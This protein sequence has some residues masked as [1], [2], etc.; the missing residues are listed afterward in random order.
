[1]ALAKTGNYQ[2][3]RDAFFKFRVLCSEKKFNWKQI[4]AND[5]DM[6]KEISL[7]NYWS[8]EEATK[9][10]NIMSQFKNDLKAHGLNMNEVPRPA[11]SSSQEPKK[12]Q[13]TARIESLTYKEGK[14]CLFI[15]PNQEKLKDIRDLKT[16]K[17]RNET[18]D[19]E[20][21]ND[22]I[23]ELRGLCK[24]HNIMIGY[25]ASKMLDEYESNFEQSYS[26][27]RVELNLPFR[28]NV[29]PYDYQTV[30]ISFGIRTLKSWNCD[31]MGLGKTIQG[32][33]TALGVDQW[34]VIV[35]CPKSLRYNWKVEIEKFTKK[36][37]IIATHK[38]MEDL[39][40]M[41]RRNEFDFLIMNHDG[42]KSFFVNEIERKVDK[43]NRKRVNVTL[44]GLEKLFKGIIIDEVHEFKNDKSDR[45]RVLKKV[46]SHMEYRQGLT[47][48]PYVNN[49]TDI[50]NQLDLLGRIDDFGGKWKF[51]KEYAGMHQKGFEDGISGKK[52]K[53]G[54]QNL[55][56]LNIKL[57]TLCMIRREKHQV[58]T[59]LPDK[60]RRIVRI[61]ISNQKEYAHAEF[62]LKSYLMSIG[63]SDEKI[64]GAER[65]NI[66]TQM[67]VLKKLS[68]KGKVE[69][70][71]D[72]IKNIHN[73]GEK[74]IVFCWHKETIER[75]REHFP[76]LVEISGNITNDNI[77]EQNKAR[78][79]NDPSCNLIVITY[80][81]GGVGHTLTAAN[82]VIFA[83]LGWN[84]KDQDQAED[85][86]HR[87]G[88]LSEV[89]CHY[90]LGK[91]TIDEA[92]MEII[93]KKRK[94]A[95]QS[96]G[97]TESISTSEESMLIKMLTNE[98]ST[99]QQKKN[100]SQTEK[101]Y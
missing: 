19:W 34:P 5:I 89:T 45:Y 66:I 43:A 12:W 40:A 91:D 69:G 4:K 8:L 84:T 60:L 53:S 36:R 68:A 25:S 55:A 87:I 99:H 18:S 28:E 62:N 57:R 15:N 78:F 75:Y 6:F 50:A 10:Y 32:I 27:Q 81:K 98:T 88:Q 94:M 13:N 58:L 101:V 21:G 86:A 1:M 44:N 73:Q 82:H 61:E 41:L 70:I 90:F 63:A 83:E 97:S 29:V 74:V 46:V 64:W 85:R 31:Q 24:K 42:P 33:G 48:T 59:E 9:F 52:E 26:A 35:C 7:K 37:A 95:D 3:L 22:C 39:P 56:D 76:D 67:Q 11:M 54:P 77:I 92:I 17:F 79:Q 51:C 72:E 38:V 93:D 71:V 2:E 65:A 96:L 80:K 100:N 16:R 49:V 30:G 47:G 20:I 23:T 14:F